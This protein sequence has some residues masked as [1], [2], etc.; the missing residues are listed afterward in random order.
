MKIK[1]FYQRNRKTFFLI[2]GVFLIIF[3]WE[4]IAFATGQKFIPEFFNTWKMMFDSCGKSTTWISAG[5]TLLRLLLSFF[6]SSLI[7][8]ILG[9][10]SGY[11][12]FLD[13]LLKPLMI[14]LRSFPTIALSMLLVVYVPHFSLYVTSIVLLPVIYQ[15]SHEG[16]QK[17]YQKYEYILLLKGKKHFSNITSVIFPLSLNYIFLGFVQA[18]GLGLKVQIMSETLAFKSNFY[19]LG[20][21]IYQSYANVEYGEMMAYVLLVLLISFLFELLLIQLKNQVEKKLNLQKK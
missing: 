7:G 6:I 18:F 17:V 5:W 4:I 8:V 16:S 19:G 21:L 9:I 15:A 11:Y 3:L 10:L 1:E 13:D 2:S 12:S 20:K 14:V